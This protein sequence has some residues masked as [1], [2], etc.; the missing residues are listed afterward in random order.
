MTLET[1]DRQ[2]HLPSVRSDFNSDVWVKWSAPTV[3]AAAEARVLPKK[4]KRMCEDAV[5][6][7]DE[8]QLLRTCC[9]ITQKRGDAG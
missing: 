8:G 4:S 7:L 5:K 2:R 9:Q 1:A 6:A 3:A